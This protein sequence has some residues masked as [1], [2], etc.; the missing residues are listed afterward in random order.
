[1]ID[2]KHDLPI[3]RQAKALNISR[4]IVYYLPPVRCPL[5]ISRSCGGWTNCIST[6]HSRAAG[7]CATCWA[8]EGLRSGRLHV[9]T[10]M[11]RMSSWP[12]RAPSRSCSRSSSRPWS[13]WQ[14]ISDRRRCIWRCCIDRQSPGSEAGDHTAEPGVGDGHHLYPYGAWPRLSCRRCRLVQPARSLLAS[15]DHHG[16]RVLHRGT[17]GSPRQIQQSRRSSTPTREPVHQLGVHRRVDQERHRDQQW[18]AKA[19]GATTSSAN[20]CGEPSNTRRRI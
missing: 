12:W 20:A 10:L 17:R 2:R 13:T 8:A 3:A 19:H 18:T 5:P 14:F 16:S 4:G 11:K 9:A 7:C 1:M 15:I 6:I